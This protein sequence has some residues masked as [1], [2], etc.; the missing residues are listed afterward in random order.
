MRLRQTTVIAL[1]LLSVLSVSWVQ[2]P[3]LQAE[4]FEYLQNAQIRPELHDNSKTL[5]T[6]SSSL[7]EQEGSTTITSVSPYDNSYVPQ[8]FVRTKTGSYL[9]LTAEELNAYSPVQRNNVWGVGIRTKFGIVAFYTNDEDT[10]WGHGQVITYPVFA[11]GSLPAFNKPVMASFLRLWVRTGGTW[12]QNWLTSRNVYQTSGVDIRDSMTAYNTS[13]LELGWN[14]TLTIN[15]F[16]FRIYNGIQLDPTDENII[17]YK[18]QITSLDRSWDGLGWEYVH[19]QSSYY[20]GTDYQIK[21]A[22]A[23]TDTEEYTYKLNQFKDVVTSIPAHHNRSTLLMSNN[24]TIHEIDWDDLKQTG[25]TDALFTIENMNLPSGGSDYVLRVGMYGIRNIPQNYR[26]EIDPSVQITSDVTRAIPKKVVRDSSNIPYVLALVGTTLKAFKGNDTSTPLSWTDETVGDGNVESENIGYFDMVIYTYSGT[27][28]IVVVRINDALELVFD[29]STVGAFTF[30]GGSTQILDDTAF[31]YFPS[32]DY[33]ENRL[34][35]HYRYGFEENANIIHST[36]GGASWSGA[37]ETWDEVSGSVNFMSSGVTWDGSYWHL[38]L[39]VDETP[40]TKRWGIVGGV[41]YWDGDSWESAGDGDLGLTTGFN[42]QKHGGAHG[43]ASS[44]IIVFS[45]LAD[46]DNYG[47]CMYSLD[48]GESW[49]ET[50]NMDR[51][52]YIG[53]PSFCLKTEAGEVDDLLVFASNHSSDQNSVDFNLYDYSGSSWSGWSL[54]WDSGDTSDTITNFAGLLKQQD[55]W[56][57]YAFQH[58]DDSES[59]Y[60]LNFTIYEEG[61]VGG[62]TTDPSFTY[63]GGSPANNSNVELGTSIL[64]NWSVVEANPSIYHIYSNET[65][66]GNISR[67]SGAYS[68]GD[69]LNWTFANTNTSNLGK[70]LFFQVWANDTSTNSNSSIV[71]FDIVDTTAPVLTYDGTSAAN[72]SN[73]E[74]N[75]SILANWSLT[76][77]IPDKYIFYCN[78]SGTNSSVQSGSWNTGEYKSYTEGNMNISNIGLTLFIQLIA[79]DTSDNRVSEVAYFNIVDNTAPTLS[80]TGTANNTEI[81]YSVAALGNWSLTDAAPHMYVFY[82]NHSAT[83]SS[84]ASGTWNSGDY[85]SWEYSNT[86]CSNVDK[87]IFIQMAANDTSNTLATEITYFTVTNPA[88][89]VSYTGRTNNTDIEWETGG[90]IT[91]SWSVTESAPDAY[92]LYWNQTGSNTTRSTGAY[93]GSVSNSYNPPLADVGNLIWFQL[94]VNDTCGETGSRSVVYFTITNTAAP[95]VSITSPTNTTYTGNITV[96]LS[97]SNEDVDTLW[98][99]LYYTN[100]TQH[101]ANTTWTISVEL[102][103]ADASYYLIGYAN[104]TASLEDSETVY[105]TISAA[106]PPSGSTGYQRVRDK[107]MEP[108]FPSVNY[109]LLG[110]LFSAVAGL[111]LQY[112]QADPRTQQQQ[113]R[114]Q[115]YILGLLAVIFYVVLRVIDAMSLIQ[116]VISFELPT[117]DYP[118]IFDTL[119]DSLVQPSLLGWP[120]GGIVL[121]AVLGLYQSANYH[122]TDPQRQYLKRGFLA[123]CGGALIFSIMQLANVSQIV[124]DVRGQEFTWPTI[125]IPSAIMEME[126]V[127]MQPA[128]PFTPLTLPILTVIIVASMAAYTLIVTRP[129]RTEPRRILRTVIAFVVW[130]AFAYVFVVMFDLAPLLDDGVNWI[131]EL[132]T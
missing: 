45:H 79:N 124:N 28:Y 46:G 120:L 76:D 110:L 115:V 97:C 14:A 32:M 132:Y 112:S 10:T 64:V 71:Y 26:I 108:L 22:K 21:Y 125:E 111:V 122:P 42:N 106:L 93:A 117:I 104:D 67:V 19:A 61:S 118:V 40:Y 12:Y 44:N 129:P 95:T 83:N 9:D 92:I 131:I 36:D 102:S 23:Y 81:E 87:V 59:T 130:G 96:T 25:F 101:T 55:G 73:V 27:E 98:Y 38:L 5:S 8:F 41:E 69:Y 100:G 80:Y 3:V 31:C 85:K 68:N 52:D 109:P 57:D 53:Y 43:A 90:S 99:E 114:R 33:G 18:H 37:I 77:L 126:A 107:L 78:A 47:R 16:Q 123:L 75:T 15:G 74:I 62:D 66:T 30:P 113:Q 94:V 11:N 17:H 128:F 65:G 84:V 89:Q 29:R 88:P 39:V 49:L 51:N 4:H 1:L 121:F 50:P 56:V 6:L 70:T 119:W 60:Y 20:D 105:F 72:N 86:N 63:D 82:S 34:V 116:R 13:T 91:V 2:E 24:Q 48:G 58:Y 7:Q 54:I 103:L 35:I 127:V